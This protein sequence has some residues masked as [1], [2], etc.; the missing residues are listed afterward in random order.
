MVNSAN[1]FHPPPVEAPSWVQEEPKVLQSELD[2]YF[3]FLT[4]ISFS[5]LT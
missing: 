1:L 5:I 4:K 2:N 3:E